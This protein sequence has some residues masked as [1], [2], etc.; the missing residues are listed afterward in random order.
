MIA[1]RIRRLALA[2]TTV[3][4]LCGTAR[5]AEKPAPNIPADNKGA[6]KLVF[7][8]YPDPAEWLIADVLR[9]LAAAYEKEHPDVAIAVNPGRSYLASRQRAIDGSVA[10]VMISERTNEIRACKSQDV[11]KSKKKGFRKLELDTFIPIAAR[12]IRSEKKVLARVRLGIAT[13]R[14]ADD[15]KGFL[16]FLDT[17]AAKKALRTV[18]FIEPV[19]RRSQ[20]KT[21]REVEYR[22]RKVTLPKPVRSY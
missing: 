19:E 3:A 15:L 11:G 14:I 5:V 10:G 2:C 18:P 1:R 8:G 12:V 9:R 17:D 4:A 16:V 7:A 20:P 22:G 21:V 6:V 13:D